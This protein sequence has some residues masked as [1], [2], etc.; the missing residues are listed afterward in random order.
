MK[1]LMFISFICAFALTIIPVDFDWRWWRP[2][3]VLLLVIYWSMYASQYFGLVAAWCVGLIMDLLLMS[4]LGFHSL[5]VLLVSYIA[6]LSY[7][8][9]RNYV[10]WHQAIW[11]F[12]LIGLFQL[13]SNWIGGFFDKSVDAPLFLTA[14]IV[15][16]LLWPLLV[17]GM[18]RTMVYFRLTE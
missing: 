3:F 12:V 8:R 2:E 18:G 7:R 4:P 16:G 5:S 14:A 1:A 15:S 9:I 13:F 6:H 17:V 10:L 11:V